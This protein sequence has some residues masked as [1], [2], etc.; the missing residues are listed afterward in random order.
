LSAEPFWRLRENTKAQNSVSRT[1]FSDTFP[2]PIPLGTE[3]PFGRRP[4]YPVG[5]GDGLSPFSGGR[6]WG[7]AYRAGGGPP[8]VLAA[9]L[10]PSA[11]RKDTE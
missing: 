3:V 7:S 10:V 4:V 6:G 2:F 1:H 8:I 5:T 9:I 11:L